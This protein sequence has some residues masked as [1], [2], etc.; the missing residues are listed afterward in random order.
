MQ[1]E[2]TVISNAFITLFNKNVDEHSWQSH[3]HTHTYTRKHMHTE[4]RPLGPFYINVLLNI[5]F[6]SER[7]QEHNTLLMQLVPYLFATHV[8]VMYP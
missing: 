1:Q 3:T 6:Y 7:H 2:E 5:V 8:L 4:A